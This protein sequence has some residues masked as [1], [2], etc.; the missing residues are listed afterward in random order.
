M[1]GDLVG[2]FAKLR[3]AV[4]ELNLSPIEEHRRVIAVDLLELAD[5]AFSSKSMPYGQAWPQSKQ[6][7]NT[8]ERSGA[9]RSRLRVRRSGPEISIVSPT[10]YGLYHQN[11]AQLR[12]RRKRFLFSGPVRDKFVSDDP[13]NPFASGTWKKG[14]RRSKLLKQTGAE[15]GILPT[16]AFL[17]GSTMPPRWGSK[18]TTSCNVVM[19][20]HFRS[21]G[22]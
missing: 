13:S 1:G 22:G 10:R 9:L 18:I 16:R 19:K 17:P 8:L 21:A 4:R 11:G 6:N 3:A 14:R 12:G 5:S 20:K 7:G 2:D 15:R